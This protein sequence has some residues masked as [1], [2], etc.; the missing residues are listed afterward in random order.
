VDNG[1]ISEGDKTCP[2]SPYGKSKLMVEDVLK[3][4]GSKDFKYVILRYFN[5]AGANLDANLGQR[6]PGSNHLIKNIVDTVL[7]KKDKLIIF[8]NDYETKDGTAVRDYIHIKDLAKAHVLSLEYEGESD[9][10]NIGYGTGYTVKEVLDEMSK[11]VGKEIPFEYGDRRPGDIG[12]VL[13]RNERSVNILGFEQEESL[14]SIC[15]DSL[16]FALLNK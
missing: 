9:I 3:D 16:E 12:C 15:M 13:T 5:V 2:V 10:F 8:G 7:G 4:M 1:N 14:S 11:I 6:M